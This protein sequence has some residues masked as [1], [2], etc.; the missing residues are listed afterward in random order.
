GYNAKP[1][2]GKLL[3][4]TEMAEMWV[5]KWDLYPLGEAPKYKKD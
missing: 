3:V 1:D 2:H 5:R 4:Q